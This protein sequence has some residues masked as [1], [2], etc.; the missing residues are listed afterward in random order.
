MQSLR[1][2]LKILAVKLRC[3]GLVPRQQSQWMTPSIPHRTHIIVF[4]GC[5][6]C[7]KRGLGSSSLSLAI[8]FAAS[9]LPVRREPI[10]HRQSR[11]MREMVGVKFMRYPWF[12]ILN[13]FQSFKMIMNCLRCTAAL[14]MGNRVTGSPGQDP[15]FFAGSGSGTGS[16]F[17][18]STGSGSGSGS[19][20]K[21]PGLTR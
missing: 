2:T 17:G 16:R 3:Y 8:A 20:A 9:C 15:A 11:L 7:L 13:F 10:S 6:F 18:R 21:K 5:K 1:Q 12:E 19:A 14:H 4:R